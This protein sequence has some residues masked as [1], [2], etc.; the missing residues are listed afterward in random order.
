MES[1]MQDMMERGEAQFE[2]I[3]NMLDKHGFDVYNMLDSDILRHASF[4]ETINNK[5]RELEQVKAER[6]ELNALIAVLYSTLGEINLAS[7]GCYSHIIEDM[8]KTQHDRV[9]SLIEMEQEK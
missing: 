9:K 3:C 4:L 7:H 8:K 1:Q 2:A 5:D 6:G